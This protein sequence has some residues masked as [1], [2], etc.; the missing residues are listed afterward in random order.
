VI[1]AASL[2]TLNQLLTTD[3]MAQTLEKEKLFRKYLQHPLIES[4]NGRGLMLAVIVKTAEIAD[5]VVNYCQDKGLIVYWLL[6]EHR[7]VRLS[8]PLTLTDEEIKEGCDIIL[9]ALNQ[10]TGNK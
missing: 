2:A 1:A 5:F 8:P 9:E 3:L 10:V 7:A 6:F 4:I